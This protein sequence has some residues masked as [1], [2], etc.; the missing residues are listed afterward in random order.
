MF[1]FIFILFKVIIILIWL[2]NVKKAFQDRV[3]VNRVSNFV[4]RARRLE[5]LKF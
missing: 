3:G 5:L 2:A 4:I 1:L